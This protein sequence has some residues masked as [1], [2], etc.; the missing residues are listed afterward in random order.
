MS[1]RRLQARRS[2]STLKVAAALAL[3]GAVAVV[4]LAGMPGTLTS[5][6]LMALPALLLAVALLGGNYP[7]ERLLRRWG[8]RRSRP[9]MRCGL[10][11]ALP[12]PAAAMPRGGSLIASAL[13]GRAP[14]VLTTG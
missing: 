7:G 3:V 13:A 10:P 11:P 14:P 12:R 6:A 5:G 4:A 1:V 2:L 9:R 8:S